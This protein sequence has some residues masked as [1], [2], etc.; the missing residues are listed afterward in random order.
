MA[1]LYRNRSGNEL[2][3]TPVSEVT[4]FQYVESNL[5]ALVQNT[6][7]E[8]VLNTINVKTINFRWSTNLNLTIARNRLVSYPGLASSPYANSLMVGKPLTVQRLFHEI[9]VNDTTGLYQF[10]S[11]QGP[12]YSPIFYANDP[13]ANDQ[14]VLLDLTPKFY[15]GLGNSFSYKNFSLDFF[16]QFV[17]QTGKRFW[18]TYGNNAMPGTARNMPSIILGETW[19]K[20]GDHKTYQ[21]FSQSIG[22]NEYSTFSTAHVSDFAYGDASYIRLK[23][24]QISWQMPQALEKKMGLSCRFYIQCQNLLTI[25]KYDGLDPE[26][27]NPTTGPRRGYVGG[28]QLGL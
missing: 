9:G 21:Q 6:G 17:K 27:Q 14:N 11:K 1:S 8:F 16:F 25:T 4:G 2:V 5:P 28:I 7:E 22:S 12:T 18:S 3:R 15:G 20:P 23:N 13:T 19:Q 10:A 26:S 24:V